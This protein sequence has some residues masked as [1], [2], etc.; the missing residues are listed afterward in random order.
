[1]CCTRHAGNTGRKKSPSGHH[2]RTLLACIFAPKARM[3]NWKKNLLNTDTSCTCPHDMVNFGLLTTEIC[4]RVWSTPAH[5][6]GFWV[7]AA[8]LHGTPILGVSQTLRRSTQ[9]S[10]CIRQGGPYVGHWPTFL[11]LLFFYISLCTWLYLYFWLFV[12]HQF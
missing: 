7:L 8:F 11:V 5:F 4:W 2:R 6:N 12:R 10:T 3:D 1:M 9:G